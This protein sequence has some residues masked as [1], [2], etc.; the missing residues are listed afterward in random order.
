M[1]YTQEKLTELFTYA[2]DLFNETIDEEYAVGKGGIAYSVPPEHPNRQSCASKPPKL[3][4]PT[5]QVE[6]GF[7]RGVHF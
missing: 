6:Q 1:K 4:R 3:S 5:A 7:R 2:V